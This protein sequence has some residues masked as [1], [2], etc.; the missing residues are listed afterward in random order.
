MVVYVALLIASLAVLVPFAANS[1]SAAPRT[2][3]QVY[4]F[5][6]YQCHGYAGNGS[7]ASA[8]YLSPPPRDFT[9]AGNL[10][11]ERM[12]QSVTRG[13]PGTAMSSF[14]DV[15]D[16]HEIEAV[17]DYVVSTFMVKSPPDYR[18]HTTENGW[19][20]HERYAPAFPFVLGQLSVRVPEARL[21]AMQLLGREMFLQ[22]CINCHEPG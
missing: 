21:D 17:V 22:A 3:E 15:L 9:R 8:G 11:R 6:C 19:P 4:K 18:Y 20:E 2:G 1:G 14:I 12:V 7:T 16:R 10:T 5:Y 13:R